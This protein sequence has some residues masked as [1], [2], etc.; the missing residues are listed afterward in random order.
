ME[1]LILICDGGMHNLEYIHKHKI[2]PGIVIFDINKFQE[3]IPYLHKDD[4]ILLVIKGLTDFKMSEVYALMNK[5]K[6]NEEKIK[7]I[8]ILSNITLGVIPYEY[9]LYEGDLFFGSVKLL[10]GKDE[11]QIDQ[12]GNV[13]E[14]KGRFKRKQ[15]KLKYNPITHRYRKYNDRKVKSVFYGNKTEAIEIKEEDDFVKNILIVDIYK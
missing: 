3:I 15:E 6:E 14:N 5:F 9:Y 10:S 4:E 7:D 12:K 8:T 1:R 11:F 13:I 2:Y